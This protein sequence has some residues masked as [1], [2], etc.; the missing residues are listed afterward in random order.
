MDTN[1]FPRRLSDLMSRKGVSKYKIAQLCGVTRWTVRRW[2]L[3]EQDPLSGNL[4]ELADYF[5]VS[6]DYLLG[7]TNNPKTNHNLLSSYEN[8]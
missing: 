6:A 5:G 1:E 4:R 7:R 3:G 8:T 2:E